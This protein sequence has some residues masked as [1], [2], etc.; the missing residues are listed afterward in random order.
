VSTVSTQQT[1]RVAVLVDF[2][3]F[4]P[5]TE[6]G[7]EV[8]WVRHETNRMISRALEVNPLAERVVIRLWREARAVSS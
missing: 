1:S 5:P 3:N 2:D 4:F 6:A 7:I 8:E